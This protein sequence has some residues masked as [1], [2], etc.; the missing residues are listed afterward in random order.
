MGITGMDTH[1]EGK[2]RT[3][4]YNKPGIHKPGDPG[5]V[6]N[7]SWAGSGGWFASVVDLGKF[8][9]GIRQCKVLSPATTEI[10]LKDGLGWDGRDPWVKFGSFS[11]GGHRYSV[12]LYS[13]EGVDAVIL[14]NSEPASQITSLT[15]AWTD[16]H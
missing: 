16:A 3:C 11:Q 12:I 10:M 15:Q 4:I 7:S 9:E 13:R 14:Y 5:Y 2:K 8:L 6:D 1:N